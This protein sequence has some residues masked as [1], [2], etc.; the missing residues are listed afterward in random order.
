MSIMIG[1]DYDKEYKLFRIWQLDTCECGKHICKKFI[2]SS[3]LD[4]C[5]NKIKIDCGKQEKLK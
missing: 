4:D 2:Y 1:L 5:L 3:S